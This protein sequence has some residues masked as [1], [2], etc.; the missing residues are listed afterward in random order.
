MFSIYYVLP[1]SNPSTAFILKTDVYGLEE[2]GAVWDRLNAQFKMLSA[3][4]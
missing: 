2:A 1:D 3:K 4:P